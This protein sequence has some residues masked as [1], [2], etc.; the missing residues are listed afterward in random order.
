MT[1]A[2]LIAPTP[3]L[4]SLLGLL[5]LAVGSFLNVVVHRVPA[6]LSVVSPPS[7]CPGCEHEVRP[8]DNI[9]VVSWLV[10]RGHC[11][12]CAMPISGR[13]PLVEAATGLAFAF[14]AW[15]L[16][17]PV[18]L[19]AGLVVVAAGIALTLIDLEHGRLP[20][21]ITGTTSAL[22]AVVLAVAMVAGA[23]LDL[24]AIVSSTAIWLGLYGGVWLVTSGRGMGLGDVALA[25]L[26]GVVLGLWGLGPSL[27][28][29]MAGFAVG[30]VCVLSLMA[31]GR[32][33]RGAAVPHGP[34]MLVG[35][36]IGLFAGEPIAQAYL[37]LVGLA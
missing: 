1:G 34:F 26:L 12:D 30:A 31:A 27:V 14:T 6:G 15:R 11:R 23:S 21:S 19:G 4:V 36:A 2:A 33:Q 16:T 25:P 32:L 10:L 18:L 17:D 7:A 13:Y 28:G 24:T 8:R 5:G 29:L 37:R 9:P 35:A 20:F 22:V 3:L